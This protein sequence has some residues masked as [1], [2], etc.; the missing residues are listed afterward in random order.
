MDIS[1]I[2][3][4]EAYELLQKAYRHASTLPEPDWSKQEGYWEK[5][6]EAGITD[7]SNPE[8]PIKRCEVMAHL[9]RLGLL[10]EQ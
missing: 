8:R 10:E 7:G 3:D 5:A 4:Q 6:T 1:K 2:T 9:G